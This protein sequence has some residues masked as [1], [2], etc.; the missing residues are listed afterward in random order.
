MVKF[1]LVRGDCFIFTLS[2]SANI[3]LLILHLLIGVVTEDS[4]SQYATAHTHFLI[5]DVLLQEFNQ[6]KD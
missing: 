1:S 6:V 2:L 4:L 3:A 5:Y